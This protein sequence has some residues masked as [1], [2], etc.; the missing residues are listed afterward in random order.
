MGT[1]YQ[2]GWV[3]L[4]GKKWYGYF[5]RTE[6]DPSTSEPKPAV[7]Q[8]I[9]G[10]KSEMSKSQ[11]RQKL[12]GE[13]T[14][15]G[16]QPLNSDKSMVNGGVTF[17]WFVEHRYLPLKEADWRESSASVKKHIIQ[18]D[19]VNYFEDEGLR[20]STSSHSRRTSTSWPRRGRRTECCRYAR[21]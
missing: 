8:V 16:T 4:R 11:A 6:I 20:T 2:K 9:L 15:L 17:G 12:E 21:T 19:L 1:S 18:A 10:F 7:A 3:R 13:I 5:R 14:K